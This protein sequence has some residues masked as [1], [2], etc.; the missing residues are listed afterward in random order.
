MNYVEEDTLARGDLAIGL[1]SLERVPSSTRQN[2]V[3]FVRR[4]YNLVLSLVVSF[5]VFFRVFTPP[6]YVSYEM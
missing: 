5:H 1:E 2:L 4:I 3:S 6:I